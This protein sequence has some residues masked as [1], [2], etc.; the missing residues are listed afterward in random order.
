MRQPDRRPPGPAAVLPTAVGTGVCPVLRLVLDLQ[1]LG[2][3]EIPLGS[4]VRLVA[5]E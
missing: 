3:V 4:L 5:A 1:T 2:R